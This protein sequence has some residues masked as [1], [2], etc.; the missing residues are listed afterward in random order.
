[1]EEKDLHKMEAI[2]NVKD[3]KLLSPKQREELYPKIIKLAKAYKVIIIE[4]KEI[5]EA[6]DGNTELNLNW[7]EA[8]KTAEIINELKPD[9]AFIDCPSNNIKA[10]HTYL[11]KLIKNKVE[12]VCDHKA[13]SKYKLVAAAS[14]IAK[15]TRDKEIAEIQKG[16][17]ED[18]GS[19]YPADPRTKKFVKENHEAYPDILRKSWATYKQILENKKQKSLKE[20][21]ED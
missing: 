4:P 8:I 10:Y 5:D 21:K 20:F 17:P 11:S 6:V 15:V 7:L 16:I 9:R 14:I 19:G 1:M 18:I 3:S 12:L 13:E 2:K